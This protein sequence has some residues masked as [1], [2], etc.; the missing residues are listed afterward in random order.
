MRTGSD[1]PVMSRNRKLGYRDQITDRMI[2]VTSGQADFY[3]FDVGQRESI[4]RINSAA[5]SMLSRNAISRAGEGLPSSADSFRHAKIAAITP[6]VRLRP[7]SISFSIGVLRKDLRQRR[8]TTV[9]YVSIRRL[10]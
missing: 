9:Y 5:K 6:R 2:R 8:E 10:F 4:R 1:W 7:S 3:R